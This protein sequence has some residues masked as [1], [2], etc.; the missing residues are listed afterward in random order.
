MKSFR[1]EHLKNCIRILVFL[2]LLMLV[3]HRAYMVLNWKDTT[4]DY[5]SSLS[6]LYHTP[7]DTIDVV[8][9]GSSHCYCG[10]YPAF[11]WRDNGIAAFDMSVSGQDRASTYHMLLETLK[12]QSPKVVMVDCYG[13]LFDRNLLEGNVYRNML[14]MKT[15]KNSIELVKEYVEPE[16]QLDFFLK[17]PIIHTRFWEVGKYDFIQY[18]PSIYGRGALFSWHES[19]GEEKGVYDVQEAGTLTDENAAW[20]DRLIGVSKEYGFALEFFVVPFQITEEEQLQVNAAKAYLEERGIALL[21]LNQIRD[22]LKLDSKKDF[23]DDKHCNAIGAEKVTC[24][25]RD[26]LLERYEF[27]DHRGEE[28]Y[29]YWDQDLEWY[30]HCEMKQ[31]IS[32][33]EGPKEQLENILN[34][35]NLITIISVEGTTDQA[36]FLAP[37]GLSSEDVSA[38]GKW[39]LRDD[40][41]VKIMENEEGTVPYIEDLNA[42]DALRIQYLG[43]GEGSNVQINYMKFVSPS[44]PITIVCYDAFLKE[45]I[46]A[47]HL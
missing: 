1:K 42:T 12:T 32:V 41:L 18:E 43:E 29:A 13:L 28:A 17:W 38:G 36:D 47:I 27:S 22:E 3:L 8:F 4:G 5:L 46:L 21:D 45:T 23:M 26:Y 24:Y 6:Q 30:L 35:K 33:A 34:Q 15:S 19:E 11:L 20:L 2:L 10:V 7:E 37:L 44:Y 40:K 25:L 14:S 31:K 39:I 16:E 9:M